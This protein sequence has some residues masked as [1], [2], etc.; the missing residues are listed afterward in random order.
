MANEKRLAMLEKLTQSGAADSFAWYGLA[1]EYSSAGR[2]DEALRAFRTLRE[3]DESYVPMYLICGTMLVR[4]GRDG[5]GREWLEAGI[6]MARKSGNSH[7]LREL[8]EALGQ[9]PPPPSLA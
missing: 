2:I 4:A 7:A 9:I 3:R 8:E 6:T 5:E 1:L